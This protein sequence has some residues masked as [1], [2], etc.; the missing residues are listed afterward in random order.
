MHLLNELDHEIHSSL[1]SRMCGWQSCGES[2]KSSRRLGA[3]CRRTLSS[4]TSRT[5]GMWIG[6]ARINMLAMRRYLQ[7]IDWLQCGCRKRHCCEEGTAQTCDVPEAK[8]NASM[9]RVV[10]K[11]S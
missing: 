9:F 11:K 7:C 8:S 10:T 5:S 1:Q 2:R 3:A 4:P 6:D